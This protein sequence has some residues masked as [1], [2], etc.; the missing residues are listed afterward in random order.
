MNRAE[1]A[2]VLKSARGR[3]APE[4]VGLPAGRR[5]RV[6][7][8]R[9]EEVAQLAGISVDYLVRLE[10]GRGPQPS[11]QVLNALT[12]TL[13]LESD[14]R[15]QLF[16]LA[17]SAPPLAGQIEMT[18][19]PSILRLL[20]RFTDMPSMI[21]SAKG[22]VLAQNAIGTAL[23]GDFSGR[24]PRQRNIVWQ[25]FL[26]LGDDRVE[27]TPEGDELTARQAVGTLRSA[28]ARYP[29]DPGLRALLTE[30]HNGSERFR[31]IW[32]DSKPMS[33]RSMHKTI[34]H[35]ELGPLALD[36]DGLML[37]DTDQTMIVYSAAAGSPAAS[38]LALLGVTGIEQMAAPQV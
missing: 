37:P 24:L 33:W 27:I 35:P 36:C 17:G 19:R 12:R 8:L 6:P 20:E 22:D 13:R 38:A 16:R 5:R 10:Q 21:I 28:A 25:R 26:G 3:I 9:R 1:L 7:G 30:L 4:E 15:D 34:T 23:L 32:S 14:E 18:V 11:T 31:R 2:H 29:D